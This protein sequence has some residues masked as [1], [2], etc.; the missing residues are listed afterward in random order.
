MSWYEGKA[1]SEV[2]EDVMEEALKYVNRVLLFKN[3]AYEDHVD[4]LITQHVKIQLAC[5]QHEWSKEGTNKVTSA[6][7]DM[8]T[9][10]MNLSDLSKACGKHS[11]HVKNVQYE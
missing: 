9:G 11:L 6:L 4:V 1:P 10:L 7:E 3:N 2:A 5:I 8:G